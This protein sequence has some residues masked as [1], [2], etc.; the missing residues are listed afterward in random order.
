M[1]QE[2]SYQNNEM[3]TRPTDMAFSVYVTF[4]Q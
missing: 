2:L 4:K 1:D 3:V